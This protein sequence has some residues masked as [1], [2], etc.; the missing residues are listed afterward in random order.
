MTFEEWL[1][2]KHLG[3]M[4]LEFSKDAFVAGAASRDAEIAK[5]FEA[6]RQSE[7]EEIASLIETT[8]LSAL[9]EDMYKRWMINTLLI[10]TNIIRARSTK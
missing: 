2:D 9:P 3:S 4:E 6:G 7:R 5:A 8:D 10:Y 1:G